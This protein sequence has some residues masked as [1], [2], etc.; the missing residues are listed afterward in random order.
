MRSG[1]S[2]CNEE[3]ICRKWKG[4]ARQRMG[5]CDGVLCDCFVVNWNGLYECIAWFY[6]ERMD[7]RACEWQLGMIKEGNACGMT[8]RL[9]GGKLKMQM[10]MLEMQG[11]PR[12]WVF[13][14]ILADLF[15]G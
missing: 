8:T 5:F 13:L 6:R 14:C 2:G 15:V 12:H 10:G 11:W 1:W 9:V 7:G 3:K 4:Y